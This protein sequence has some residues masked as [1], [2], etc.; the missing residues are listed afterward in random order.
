MNRQCKD[1]TKRKGRVI[2]AAH[3]ERFDVMHAF[4]GI[5]ARLSILHHYRKVS[6]ANNPKRS[7]ETQIRSDYYHRLAMHGLLTN[8]HVPLERS[9]SE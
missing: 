7:Y 8:S 4:Y 9:S 6:H 2:S 3:I 1:S 5:A